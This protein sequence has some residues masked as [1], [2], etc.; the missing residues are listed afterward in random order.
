MTKWIEK[1][2]NFFSMFKKIF[3]TFKG[4]ELFYPHASS[5]IKPIWGHLSLRLDWIDHSTLTKIQQIEKNQVLYITIESYHRKIKL[6]C[7]GIGK[8]FLQ[9]QFNNL[10]F[11]SKFIFAATWF[12]GFW[13]NSIAKWTTKNVIKPLFSCGR[14][15]SEAF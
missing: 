7:F 9:C 12:F 2:S 3:C 6:W 5:V 8:Y 13:E 4:Q 15:E 14:H 11:L 10:L 1:F